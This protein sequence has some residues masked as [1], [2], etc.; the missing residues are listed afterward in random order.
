MDTC[1]RRRGRKRG[2]ILSLVRTVDTYESAIEYDLMTRTGRTLDELMR[3]GAAGKVA[4]IHF[5]K[6]LPPDAMTVRKMNP[7]E[8]GW[9]WYTTAKT[10]VILADIFDAFS[11]VHTKKGRKPFEYPRPKKKRNIGKGAIPVRDFWKW[12]NKN[13][14]ER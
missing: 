14:K 5:I 8:E 11:A 10:N 12:W 3:M 13:G 9:E 7:N 2:G 6:Y 4:L 1:D